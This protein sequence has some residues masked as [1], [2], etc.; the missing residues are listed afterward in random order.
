MAVRG[1]VVNEEKFYQCVPCEKGKTSEFDTEKGV[2]LCENQHRRKHELQEDMI[3]QT[4]HAFD[5]CRMDFNPRNCLHIACTEVLFHDEY[6][7]YQYQHV[8]YR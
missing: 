1:C 5:F 6:Y 2:L 8:P 7:Y 4:I 3:K